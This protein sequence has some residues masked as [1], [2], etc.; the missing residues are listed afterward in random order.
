MASKLFNKKYQM[1]NPDYVTPLEK[2]EY[3]IKKVPKYN[4]TKG[5]N[6]KI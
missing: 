1:T 6:E 2:Q 4:L 5:I 3:V